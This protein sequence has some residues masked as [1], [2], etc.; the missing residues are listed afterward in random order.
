MELKINAE[1]IKKMGTKTDAELARTFLTK[2]FRPTI[3]Y[4]ILS[5]ESRILIE[6]TTKDGS[7]KYPYY[8]SL[9]VPERCYFIRQL[10]N[11]YYSLVH[12]PK[13]YDI[14]MEQ[15]IALFDKMLEENWKTFEQERI[16]S[17]KSAEEQGLVERNF[18]NQY[19]VNIVSKTLSLITNLELNS[20]NNAI[21]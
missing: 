4:P 17:E 15:I 1:I 10:V 12:D 3:S 7:Y 5:D 8:S 13:K 11:R 21:L 18:T 9:D 6:T 14:K 19:T 2:K 20:I 16:K